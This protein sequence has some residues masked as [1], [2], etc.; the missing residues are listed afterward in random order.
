[1]SKKVELFILDLFSGIIGLG[2]GIIVPFMISFMIQ[3]ASIDMPREQQVA[4]EFLPLFL[5][6]I[7]ASVCLG[8]VIQIYKEVPPLAV[9]YVGFNAA[10]IWWLYLGAQLPDADGNGTMYELLLTVHLVLAGL[11]LVMTLASKLT[12]VTGKARPGLVTDEKD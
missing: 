8:F 4:R 2:F 1:M 7:I 3:M 11:L 5:V 12:F 10:F 6:S 9:F